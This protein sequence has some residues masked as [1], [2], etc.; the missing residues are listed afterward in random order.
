MTKLSAF[1]WIVQPDTTGALVYNAANRSFAATGAGST[2]TTVSTAL[3]AATSDNKDLVGYIVEC[4]DANNT[5]NQGLRRRVTSFD[6][7][8]DEITHDPFPAA[9]AS[10]DQ[11]MLLQPPHALAIASATLDGSSTNTYFGTR[12]LD[13]TDDYWNG[14]AEEG[15]PYVEVIASDNHST[16]NHPRVTDFSNSNQRV[17]IPSSTNLSGATTLGDYMELWKHPEISGEGLLELT[18]EMIER[19]AFTGDYGQQAQ[20]AG[21]RIGSGTIGLMFRGPG[22]GREGQKAECHES[23]QCVFDSALDAGDTT[24]NASPSVTNLTY[25]SSNHTVGTMGIVNGYAAMVTA[26]SGSALTVSPALGAAP[27]AAD[28]FYGVTTYTPTTCLNKALAIKQWNGKQLL[29]YAWG[30]VPKITIQGDGRGNFLMFNHEFQVADWMT[31]G[32]SGTEPNRTWYPRL[33]TVAPVKMQDSR[34]VIDSVSWGLRAFNFDPGQD[35]QPKPN[36][37]APNNTDGFEIVN[38]LPVGQMTV[39]YDA[40]TRKSIDD[41]LAGKEIE[42]LIQVGSNP[43][44]P[45]MFALWAEK[46]RYTGGNNPGDDAGQMILT[47]PFQV[48][49]DPTSALPRWAM[50]VG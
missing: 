16:T 13:Q 37:A 19:P 36:T 28:I 6:F 23:F 46:I 24:L 45:G 50:C 30:C 27:Q 18:E 29:S 44:F 11:F 34:C 17:Y 5:Q 35:I 2:T 38:D 49:T 41:F 26:D 10:G 3:S 42:L 43:G 31:L 1:S 9:T 14:V 12:D 22:P 39:T 47:L 8:S 4:T 21:D 25:A 32:A 48:V 40:I 15:G 7:S 20:V 33:P